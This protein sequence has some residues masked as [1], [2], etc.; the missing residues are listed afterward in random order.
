M[1]LIST[2]DTN[3]DRG[4]LNYEIEKALDVYELPLIIAYPGISERDHILV[5]PLKGA[6][7]E[8]DCALFM[9]RAIYKGINKIG[10]YI[11]INFSVKCK[12]HLSVI[13]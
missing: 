3:Y 2:N 8:Q 7:P 12:F 9:Y 10:T 4:F 11:L 13:I 6:F 5:M 1:F